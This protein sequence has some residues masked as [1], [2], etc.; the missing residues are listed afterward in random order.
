MNQLI[1]KKEYIN[2]YLVNRKKIK[3][4]NIRV[5]KNGELKISAPLNL[6]SKIISDFIISKEIWIKRAINS[7]KEELKNNQENEYID[8]EI[9]K[10]IGKEYYLKVI[11]SEENKV[12]LK[13][14]SIYLYTKYDN[15]IYKKLLIE[16]WYKEKAKIIFDDVVSKWL[17]ILN[18]QI[19]HLSIKKMITRWGSCN[20]K[21]RYI[22]LNVELVKRSVFEIEYVVLHEL[23]HLKY[24]HHKK[25]FYNY[26][27][28]YMPNY[29][30]AEK[31]LKNRNI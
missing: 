3:N 19:N 2:G 17:K 30:E 12:V 31:L 25:S 15:K 13:D 6:N 9:F 29:K 26:V 1:E 7:K 20:Y 27:E 11:L 21:K 10:V 5:N 8:D 16:K 22:N 4:I 24:P 18:E 14:K 23:T 28:K